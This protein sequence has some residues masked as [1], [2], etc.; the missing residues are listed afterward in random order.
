MIEKI[1]SLFANSGVEVDALLI[2]FVLTIVLGFIIISPKWPIY[3]PGP[4]L[5]V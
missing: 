2:S 5:V 4:I 3:N 1:K